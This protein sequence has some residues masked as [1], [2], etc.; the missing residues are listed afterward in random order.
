MAPLGFDK[1]GRA[2]CSHIDSR[3]LD[4][5]RSGLADVLLLAFDKLV[6]IDT[7]VRP[8]QWWA[9]NWDMLEGMFTEVVQ[10]FATVAPRYKALSAGDY[11]RFN[12]DRIKAGARSMLSV[13]WAAREYDALGQLARV[14]GPIMTILGGIGPALDC[15]DTYRRLMPHGRLEVVPEGGH[16][17][18]I[19]EPDIFVDLL[20]NFLEL[21]A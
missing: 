6:I 1:S 12:I 2:S 10:P 3:D 11:R 15:A 7:M 21:R 14:K 4:L 8:N 5:P 20:V 18:M 9:D 17:L 16:F 13:C 19:D